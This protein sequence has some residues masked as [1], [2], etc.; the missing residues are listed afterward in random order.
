MQVGLEGFDVHVCLV[1]KIR[2]NFQD[3]KLSSNAKLVS[4]EYYWMLL[5]RLHI[6]LKKTTL[7]L[8]L[9][10]LVLTIYDN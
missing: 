10:H 5:Y 2:L 3:L 6:Y 4:T 1:Y 8:D 7:L 9:C